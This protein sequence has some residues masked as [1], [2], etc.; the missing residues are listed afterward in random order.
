MITLIKKRD[1]MPVKSGN[2]VTHQMRMPPVPRLINEKYSPEKSFV[3]E[4]DADMIDDVA[5]LRFKRSAP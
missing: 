5:E 4:I 1:G 2:N 3:E